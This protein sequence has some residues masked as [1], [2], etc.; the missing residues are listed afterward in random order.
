MKTETVTKWRFQL[1]LAVILSLYAVAPFIEM[2]WFADLVATA[3]T[4]FA[5]ASVS[6]KRGLLVVFSVLA[7][8]VIA[9]T[10][11][12][13]WFPGYLIAVA[14]HFLDALFQA[15]VVGAILAHVFKSTRITRETIAGAICAYLL[16]GAIWAHVFSIV[17][18]VS[19]GS[20]ADNSIEAGAASG[21][22][23]I[24]DQSDRF[25][26][27]SFVTLTTLGYG[28]M[29]P[30]TRPARNLTALEAIFGQLYLAVLIARLVGQVQLYKKRDD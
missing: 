19:P 4:I 1:L 21:P 5:L 12:A 9:G 20:F 11:Y 13:H 18:N 30:L 8:F 16:I 29:T 3:V 27:F 17:E 24:R 25:T 15:L 28:D 2:R 22:E 26:Y 6:E 7:V 10:W 23:P 14:V